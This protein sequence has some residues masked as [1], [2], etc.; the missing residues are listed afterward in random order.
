MRGLAAVL[1]CLVLASCGQVPPAEVPSS[2][3]P[4]TDATT[5]STPAPLPPSSTPL[6]TAPPVPT[7]PTPSRALEPGT[8][9]VRGTVSAGAESGCVLLS[10]GV[11]QYL[12]LGADP[13][14]AVAGAVVEVTGRPD[15]GAMTTCQQGTPFH[16]TKTQ[17]G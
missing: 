15:P 8:T 10:N 6:P 11:A 12:L 4:T 14:I 9:V 16:V 3:T 7:L 1:L 2:S 5:P 17:R 13:A